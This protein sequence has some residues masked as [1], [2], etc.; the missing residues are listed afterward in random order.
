MQLIRPTSFFAVEGTDG[1]C[2]QENRTKIRFL[3]ALKP[4]FVLLV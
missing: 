1:G 3:F 4:A 2:H